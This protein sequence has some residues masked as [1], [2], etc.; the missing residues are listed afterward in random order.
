MTA[1]VALSRD[2][3]PP[4]VSVA[5]GYRRQAAI[6]AAVAGS[7]LLAEGASAP[8]QSAAARRGLAN[9]D[10]ADAGARLRKE[11]PQWTATDGNWR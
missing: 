6:C 9:C 1:T 4:G 5:D 7:V 2:H 8:L 11:M 3:P 10:G